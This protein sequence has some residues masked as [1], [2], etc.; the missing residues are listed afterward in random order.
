MQP[1]RRDLGDMLVYSC[2]I[3]SLGFRVQGLEYKL[4]F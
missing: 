2:A 3:I 4:G 1:E